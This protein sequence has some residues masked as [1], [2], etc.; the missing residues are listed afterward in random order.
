MD[1]ENIS[2]AFLAEKEDQVK[3]QYKNDQ[4]TILS[5]LRAMLPQESICHFGMSSTNL[6]NQCLMIGKCPFSIHRVYGYKRVGLE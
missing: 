3:H 4:E 2:G 6:Q 1:L 5:S